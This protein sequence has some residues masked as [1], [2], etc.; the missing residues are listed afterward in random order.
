MPPHSTNTGPD[1]EPIT[2]DLTERFEFVRDSLL[3]IRGVYHN[4]S[5]DLSIVLELPLPVKV[6]C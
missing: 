3:Y 6:T 1:V 4:N 5:V 2:F